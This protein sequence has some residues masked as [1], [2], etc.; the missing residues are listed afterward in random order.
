MYWWWGITSVLFCLV[1]K[2]YSYG[3]KWEIFDFPNNLT[4]LTEEWCYFLGRTLVIF[5]RYYISHFLD[6][7]FIIYVSRFEK[8]ISWKCNGPQT[9][10][11]GTPRCSVTG[12]KWEAFL[13]HIWSG[14]PDSH[15][16]L[17]VTVLRTAA[18]RK[19]RQPEK[20]KTV[21]IINTQDNRL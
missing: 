15:S 4:R 11:C 18:T 3:K 16:G 8:W 14:N 1:A 10:H 12:L 19:Y 17:F 2:L 21:S 20:K 5:W 13:R 9:S 7:Y 6:V